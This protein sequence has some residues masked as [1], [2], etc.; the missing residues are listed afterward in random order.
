MPITRKDVRARIQTAIKAATL[1]SSAPTR[2]RLHKIT[3]ASLGESED[4]LRDAP[5]WVVDIPPTL[6]TVKAD[7]ARA[8]AA[9]KLRVV[10]TLRTN[11]TLNTALDVDEAV[12][13]IKRAVLGDV[14]LGAELAEEPDSLL[15]ADIGNHTYDVNFLIP[16]TQP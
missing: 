14:D 8:R 11:Q 13:A 16:L 2:V 6:G 12:D 15:E 3:S 10:V 9:E 5:G 7:T 1:F 4:F